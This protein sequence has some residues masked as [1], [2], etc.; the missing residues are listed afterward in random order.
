MSYKMKNDSITINEPSETELDTDIDAEV[1]PETDVGV[2]A[3]ND[4]SDDTNSINDDTLI[5]D[6]DDE[7]DDDE[8]DTDDGTSI[9]KDIGDKKFD[10]DDKLGKKTIFDSESGGQPFTDGNGY[11]VYPIP[12]CKSYIS[13]EN[14]E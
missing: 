13:T 7:G 8:D 12:T 1:Y 9:Y 14:L 6:D 10:A 4:L 3:D 2:E 11:T 5:D